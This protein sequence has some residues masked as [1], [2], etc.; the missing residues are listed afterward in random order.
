MLNYIFP[1]SKVKH[2]HVLISHVYSPWTM[3][4]S[5]LTGLRA[6]RKL[7]SQDAG[8]L[9]AQVEALRQC[10]ENASQWS[11]V[12]AI[13]VDGEDATLVH[14]VAESLGEMSKCVLQRV[15]PWGAFTPALNGLLQLAVEHK[16]DHVLYLSTE[17]DIAP[18]DVERLCSVFADSIEAAATLVAGLCFSPGHEFSVGEH[19]LSGL[20]A[21]WNTCALWNA[22]NLA[23]TGFLAISDG[24]VA[25]VAGG[26]EEVA[27]IALQQRLLPTTSR[28]YLINI[29]G[30]K[31]TWM[32]DWTDPNRVEWHRHKM[33][34]KQQ[35][36]SLQLRAL[37]LASSPVAKVAHV[38]L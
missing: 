10:A 26:I 12:V 31:I 2:L 3:S 19:P 30:S 9:Q 29:K 27:V 16:V 33:Q 38:S 20:T 22:Q 25:N 24:L 1:S 11:T 36:A 23:R 34:S 7:S 14:A 21:P 5:I 18:S 8:S 4:R 35:R 15:S 13:A 28:A 37:G 17:V 6:H 32:Q